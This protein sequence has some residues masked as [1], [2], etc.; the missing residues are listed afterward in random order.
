MSSTSPEKIY[1]DRANPDVQQAARVVSPS[2]PAAQ[3][4]PMPEMKLDHPRSSAGAPL[5]AALSG[6]A[7]R[8]LS[9]SAEHSGARLLNRA[10]H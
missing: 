5:Q 9:S 4:S 6:Q 2:F 1:S 10:V 7:E 8:A 3:G